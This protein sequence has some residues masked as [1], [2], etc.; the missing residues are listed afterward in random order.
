MK[1]L[2]Y[3]VLCLFSYF[4]VAHEVSE[5]EIAQLKAEANKAREK[6]RQ[7]RDRFDVFCSSDEKASNSFAKS[8][9]EAR[10]ESKAMSKWYR[11][12]EIS[13]NPEIAKARNNLFTIRA[14]LEQLKATSKEYKTLEFTRNNYIGQSKNQSMEL[15]D[16]Q[17]RIFQQAQEAWFNASRSLYN[18]RLKAWGAFY[19]EVCKKNE[20]PQVTKAYNLYQ[21]VRTNCSKARE[22][23]NEAQKNFDTALATYDQATHLDKSKTREKS[24]KNQISNSNK[25]LR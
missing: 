10:S 21:E 6:L 1:F 20:D 3:V 8:E 11:A 14:Q 17:Y 4:N 24:P 7:A 19:G 2:I 23:Y 9:N 25:A 12:C 22:H 16:A 18:K 15:K 13:E 5:E